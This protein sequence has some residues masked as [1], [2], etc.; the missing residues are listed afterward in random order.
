MLGIIFELIRQNNER[1]GTYG[2]K[3]WNFTKG[4]DYYVSFINLEYSFVTLVSLLYKEI[5]GSFICVCV[6][7]DVDV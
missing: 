1:W 4:K 7:Q 3:G 2:D 6:C 5:Q